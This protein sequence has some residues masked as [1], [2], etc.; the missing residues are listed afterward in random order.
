[1]FD[2]RYG[3]QLYRPAQF[4]D[5]LSMRNL[6]AE[7]DA[8]KPDTVIVTFGADDVHFVDIV[9]FC[10]TGYAAE[11]ADAVEALA[12]LR[13]PSAQIRANF[14]EKF[15]TL[16]AIL[17]RPAAPR[18]VLLHRQTIGLGHRERVLGSDQQRRD[19]RRTTSIW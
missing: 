1:L 3:G 19:R 18:V 6:N 17:D 5:W 4:G 8:A 12:A 13:D 14:N 7:Y 15:P 9:T 10:A 16:E 2:R 11:D